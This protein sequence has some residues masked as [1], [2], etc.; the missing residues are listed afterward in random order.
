MSRTGRL[1]MLMD[2][3]RGYRRPVTAARLAEQLGVSERT[4]YRDIQTLSGLGAPLEGEAGV[5]YMLKAGFFLPPLMFGADELEALVLGARWV[6]RQGDEALSAAASNALAK[7]AAATPKDLRDDMA[8]TS[9][10]VPIGQ[11]QHDATDIHVRPVREAIRYQHR[12]RM[13]YRDEHGTPSQR[14]V[15][16]FALAFLEGCRLLAAWCE[17]RAAYRHFRIDRIAAVESLGERY[18]AR[19]HDLLKTWRAEHNIREDA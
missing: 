1:F 4:I 7:I 14:V 10:W 3:M 9:L 11:D 8:E 18:P 19:R 2:A 13:C 15:W 12:L 5:G 6:R 16:P 17:L